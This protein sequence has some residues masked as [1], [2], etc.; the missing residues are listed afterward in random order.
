M[1]RIHTTKPNSLQRT[2]REAIDHDTMQKITSDDLLDGGMDYYQEIRHI[3]TDRHLNHNYRYSC[4]KCGHWVYVTLRNKKPLW[5]HYKGAPQNCPWW[6][7]EPDTVDQV[8]AKQFQ[9]QQE[10]PLHNR[11]KYLIEELLSLDSCVQNV[12]VEKAIANEHGERR[13][14]DVQATYRDKD[15]AFE[16]Q[17]ATTQI[18]IILSREKFY[19][20]QKRYLIW[21]TWQFEENPLGEIPQSLLDVYYRH[22]KNIFSLDEETIALS[23]ERKTL[24]MKVHAYGYNGWENKCISLQDLIWP[25]KRLPYFLSPPQ[26]YSADFRKRW[27]EIVTPE[28]M[29]FV[30]QER[31]IGELAVKCGVSVDSEM[32]SNLTRLFNSML[33]LER[34]KPI[35]TREDNLVMA[36]NSFLSAKTRYK[37]ATLYELTARKF[38]CNGVLDKSTVKKKLSEAKTYAQVKG[39]L[40][41]NII[42]LAF[43]DWFS[44]RNANSA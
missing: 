40:E 30:D 28:G 19:Q 38:E 44:E 35:G 24:V 14:P 9:G 34:G 2:L 8:S 3:A 36:A 41:A 23:K 4:T 22:N 29:K 32:I 42:K 43:E 37:Y 7:G 15:I 33:S 1:T 13:K 18:P 25:D 5:Q 12:V 17:L 31:L 11:L 26:T 6:T 39:T 10:S 21:L 20:Q 16:I 27:L